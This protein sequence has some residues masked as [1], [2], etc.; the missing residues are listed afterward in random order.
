MD[1]KEV[2]LYLAGIGG[3]LVIYKFLS[4]KQVI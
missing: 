1:M 3:V 4:D 2:L